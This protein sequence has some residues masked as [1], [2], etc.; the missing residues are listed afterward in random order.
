MWRSVAVLVDDLDGL[1]AVPLDADDFGEP[2]RGD[3]THGSSRLYV[4]EAC[5]VEGPED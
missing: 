4:F 3:P 2:L 1:V 5:H